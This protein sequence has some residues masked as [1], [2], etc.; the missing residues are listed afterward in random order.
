MGGA[1]GLSD[2]SN[3]QLGLQ[4]LFHNC[5]PHSHNCCMLRWREKEQGLALASWILHAQIKGQFWFITSFIFLNCYIQ[6]ES[7]PIPISFYFAE[8]PQVLTKLVILK[9]VFTV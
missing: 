9:S 4:P 6:E 7:L 8:L 3:I 2:H 1:D 5:Y